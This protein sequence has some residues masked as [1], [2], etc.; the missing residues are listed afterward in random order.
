M[1]DLTREIDIKSI[2]VVSGVT[3]RSMWMLIA[4]A[5]TFP[6]LAALSYYYLNQTVSAQPINWSYAL[7][8][9]LPNWY[10]WLLLTPAIV[11]LAKRYRLDASNWKSMLVAIH[12]PAMIVMLLLHSLANLYLFHATEM[13]GH[14]AMSGGLYRVHFMTRIHSNILSYWTVI[15]V[16]YAF[17]YYRKY[18]SREQQASQLEVRLAEA[19]LRALKMQLHPHFLFNTLNSV[20][21]L[22][23]KND[24]R[25]AVK[26]LVKLGDFLRLAL[27]NK[28][29]Q[30]IT[31]KQELEFL[32]RYLGIE[33][34]RF[35]ERLDIR[36]IASPSILE[37]FVPNMIL[38]P[39]V[40]NAVHHGIAPNAEAGRIEIEASR[41]EDSLSMS[42]RDNGPGL[43]EEK[44]SRRQGVGLSNIR[45]RL[46]NLYG[47][48]FSFELGNLPEGGF[49]ASI[50][51]PYRSTPVINSI[52]QK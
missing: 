21:A 8:S 12:I 14:D 25:T 17:D 19:N 34:I 52:A 29:V 24:N 36:F 15:G 28:G 40:E 49:Q 47:N 13:P 44:A 35:Q 2:D 41:H 5:W 3:R 22:V 7:V 10:L 18:R 23:R 30:E 43:D 39:L 6:G 20:A 26:M 9:T 16:Y 37:S 32:E 51:I 31:L 33:K 42:V 27:E 46:Q 38:Q 48:D 11:F 1:R 4:A 45:E 50:R